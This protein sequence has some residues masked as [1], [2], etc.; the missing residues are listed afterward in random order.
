MPPRVILT[1]LTATS[2]SAAAVKLSRNA[3]IIDWAP[4]AVSVTTVAA[5]GVS[6]AKATDTPE[7]VA[8]AA[9]P[10]APEEVSIK[11][12]TALAIA[13]PAAGIVTEAGAVMTSAVLK[14]LAL[15]AALSTFC[16]LPSLA[17]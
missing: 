17:I 9:V 3:G 7:P 14:R 10:P 16:A 8:T 4:S 12:A 11:V 15:I 2:P 6:E 1:V 13:V 5:A